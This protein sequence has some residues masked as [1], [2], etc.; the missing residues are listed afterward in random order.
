MHRRPPSSPRTDTLFPDT[1]LFRSSEADVAFDEAL[2]DR[3]L[4]R[5]V[6]KME[7]GRRPPWTVEEMGDRYPAMRAK[8]IG[9]RAVIRA[10]RP[11]FKLGHADRPSVFD[12]IVARLHEPALVRWMR[13]SATHRGDRTHGVSGQMGVCLCGPVAAP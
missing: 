3:A 9:F 6:T 5:L 1:T 4:R 11:R 7:A 12:A 10:I 8:V 2:T 13:R